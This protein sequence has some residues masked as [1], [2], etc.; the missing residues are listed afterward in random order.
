MATDLHANLHAWKT[1]NPRH[2]WK[3]NDD[4]GS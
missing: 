1:K 2:R 3:T 4:A